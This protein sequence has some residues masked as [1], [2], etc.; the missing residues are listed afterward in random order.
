MKY[1]TDVNE[2]NMVRLSEVLA[3]TKKW[4]EEI[5][6]KYSD[7]LTVTIVKDEDKLFVA[8]IDSDNY[9]SQISVSK[10]EWRPYRYIDFEV[11]DI[12]GDMNKQPKYIFVDDEYTSLEDI[13][14][15]LGIGLEMILSE[16]I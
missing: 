15:S 8:N 6:E 3:L 9:M 1:K 11:I 10:P 13:E 5:S 12:F 14:A 16:A 7:V 4:V 2:V